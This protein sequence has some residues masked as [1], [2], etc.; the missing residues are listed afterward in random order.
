MYMQSTLGT[1]VTPAHCNTADF[2]LR[3]GLYN[4]VLADVNPDFLRRLPASKRKRSNFC[5]GQLRVSA[6]ME[7]VRHSLHKLRSTHSDNLGR[8]QINKSA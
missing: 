5:Q 7:V 8:S 6:N 1:V 2:D 4:Y 3:Y